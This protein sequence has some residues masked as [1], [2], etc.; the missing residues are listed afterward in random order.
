MISMKDYAKQSG[1]SYEAV[2]KKVN[3][4]EKEL[5]GHIKKQHRTKYLD[6]YAVEFLEAHRDHKT[7]QIIEPDE[8]CKS[9]EKANRELLEM[10]NNAKDRIIELTEANAELQIA[11][12]EVKL[13]EEYREEDKARIKDL[14]RELSQFKAVGFGLYKKKEV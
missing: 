7:M 2:R 5:E 11:E 12:K 8:Y 6:E 14:E 3:R 13:L 10:L 9:L 4:Y 1:L